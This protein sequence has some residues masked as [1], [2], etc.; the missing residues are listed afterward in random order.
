MSI[1]YRRK[2]HSLCPS[3]KNVISP[4]NSIVNSFNFNVR[5]RKVTESNRMPRGE[6][7]GNGKKEMKFLEIEENSVRDTWEE[8]EEG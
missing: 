5:S 6:L 1:V 2:E 4:D 7:G 8:G 3:G